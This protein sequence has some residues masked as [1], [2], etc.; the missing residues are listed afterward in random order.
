M[1]HE[2]I[3]AIVSRNGKEGIIDVHGKEIVPA[4]YESVG[5]FKEGMVAVERRENDES[6]SKWGF[7]GRD[8]MLKVPFMYDLARPFAEGLA[9]VQL[10]GKWGYV[11][12]EG[13]LQIACKYNLASLFFGGKAIVKLGDRNGIIDTSGNWTVDLPSFDTAEILTENMLAISHN[14]KWGVIT[15]KGEMIIEPMYDSLRWIEGVGCMVKNVQ[16]EDL[17]GEAIYQVGIITL[18]GQEVIPMRYR[19]IGSPF[20]EGV[21]PF[22]V[23]DPADPEYLNTKFGLL[24][25]SGKVVCPPVYD[26]ATPL[27]DGISIVS[28][29]KKGA[30]H[31]HN[32][33]RYDEVF[34]AINKNGDVVIPL[35]YSSLRPIFFENTLLIASMGPLK[36][37]GYMHLNRETL[38][39]KNHADWPRYGMID[40]RGSVIVPFDY[41]H[42]EPLENE[43]LLVRLA[44]YQKY[45][46][47]SLSNQVI[48]PFQNAKIESLGKGLFFEKLAEDVCRVFDI[49]QNL[50]L[51]LAGVYVT[52]YDHQM[53]LL[54]VLDKRSGKSGYLDLEG[55]YIVEPQW[56]RPF[57]FELM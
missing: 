35:I 16:G 48:I 30:T 37:G 3:Y 44:E 11:N 31:P 2:F 23:S 33:Y 21:A 57:E 7:Y 55:N 34:G 49:Q 28:I 25:I 27:I 12:L 8:G 45:G 13:E 6:K 53:G 50:L 56:D 18:D 41:G 43:Y 39:I 46:V 36:S 40:L 24:H 22:E 20:Y 9:P 54:A 29:K 47:I 14:K 52:S 10:E 4:I 42:I 19:S 32:P 17:M 15:L 5:T 51:E 38:A 26:S 1:E